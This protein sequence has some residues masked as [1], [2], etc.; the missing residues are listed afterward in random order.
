MMLHIAIGFESL[1][2]R[3]CF[4]CSVKSEL[5]HGDIASDFVYA[6]HLDN[7]F[8]A[9]LFSLIL[10]DLAPLR[11]LQETTVIIRV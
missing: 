5:M 9:S 11:F 10:C 3:V 2:I 8:I 4:E 7:S 6:L 1:S